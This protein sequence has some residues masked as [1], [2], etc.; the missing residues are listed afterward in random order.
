M[1]TPSTLT[2]SSLLP[3][4]HTLSLSSF[5]PNK[6]L[7]FTSPKTTTFSLYPLVLNFSERKSSNWLY[8]Y[9]SSCSYVVAA[10]ATGAEVEEDVEQEEEDGVEKKGGVALD[11]TTKKPKKGKAALPLKRDRV[12]VCLIYYWYSKVSF[13]VA[14]LFSPLALLI[15]WILYVIRLGVPILERDTMNLLEIEWNSRNWPENSCGV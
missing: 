4:E 6:T 11:T 3:Q 1:A 2:L 14:F 10:V 15:A 13:L 7:F 8:G 9:G 5:K 12:C